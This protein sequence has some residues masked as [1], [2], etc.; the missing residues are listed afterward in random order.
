VMSRDIADRR[1]Y[2]GYVIFAF[3]ATGW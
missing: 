2:A 3:G 1:T